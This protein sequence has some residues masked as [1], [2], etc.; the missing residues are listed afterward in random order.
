M[1]DKK[2]PSIDTETLETVTGGTTSDDDIT[3]A[4]KGITDSLSSLKKNNSGSWMNELLPFMMLMTMQGGY[5]VG[6][7]SWGGHCGG[8][9]RNP[10]GCGGGRGGHGGWGW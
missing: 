6:G 2:L 1:A 4:L 3:N 7:G 10:C 5:M 8:C 9:G